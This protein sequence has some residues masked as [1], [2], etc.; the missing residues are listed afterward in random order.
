MRAT[1]VMM[2]LIVLRCAAVAAAAPADVESCAKCHGAN[3]VSTKE[4]VPTIAGMSAPYLEAQMSAYQK[5]QRPCEKMSGTDMCE[6]A[7]KLSTDK[8]NA[9]ATY[10][11]SQQFAAARQA[12]DQTLVAKGKSIHDARCAVCHSAGGGEPADDAGILAGQWKG[13]LVAT[14][15]DYVSGKRPAPDAMKH[16]TAS[17]SPDDVKALAAFYASEGSK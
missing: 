5:G 14:L 16:Q 4:G 8:T 15:T 10:F 12:V 17:L 11:A 3:G 1:T 2:L 13:Y 6:I 7:K 9:T